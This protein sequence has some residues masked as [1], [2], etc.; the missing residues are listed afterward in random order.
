MNNVPKMTSE[1]IN[2]MINNHLEK[3]F[4]VMINIDNG[5]KLHNTSF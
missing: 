3:S 5:N 2:E 4:M 1:N